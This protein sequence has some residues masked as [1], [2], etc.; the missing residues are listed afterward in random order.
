MKEYQCTNPAQNPIPEWM[1]WRG[2]HHLEDAPTPEK[3]LEEIPA[4]A[5]KPAAP[6]GKGAGF[7]VFTYR[8][9]PFY[10]EFCSVKKK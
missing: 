3:I 8:K 9:S 7:P 6:Q 1:S 2:Q 10:P 5:E 4:K